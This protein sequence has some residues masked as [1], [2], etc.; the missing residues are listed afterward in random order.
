VA[1]APLGQDRLPIGPVRD[2]VV[3][4]HELYDL[5]GQPAARTISR[6]VFRS[7]PLESVSHETV[8]AL[9]RGTAVPAWGKVHSI[10]V[11]LNQMGVQSRDPMELVPHFNELWLAA[12]RVQDKGPVPAATI[13]RARAASLAYR[14]PPP[15]RIVGA[16]PA[17]T[18]FFTGR[19]LLLDT[20][21]RKLKAHPHAPL[22]LFGPGGVGKTQLARE[23]ALRRG[24]DYTLL[25]WV[26]ADRAE[27]ARSSLVSLA[28]RM[29]LPL[30]QSAERT[31][32]AV[33][34]RLESER[35]S[36]LLVFDSAE[37]DEVRQLIPTIGGHVIVTSRDPAWAHDSSHTGMEVPDFDEAEAIQFLRLRDEHMNGEQATTV[38]QT[39]GR[40]PL[41]LEQVA[42]LREA[43]GS[44]WE[45]L[46]ARLDEPELLASTAEPTHYPHTVARF[47]RLALDRL[48]ATNPTA[49][50]IF[51]LFAWFGSE[52]V[53]IPLL[54]QGGGGNL[55]AHLSRTL[56]D[57]IA[58]RHGV[59]AIGRYGLARL[60]NEDERI[61]VQPLI[62]LALRHALDTKASQRSRDNVHEIL[63]AANPGWPDDLAIL[64]MHRA[65]APHILSAGLV[66]SRQPGAHSAVYDQIRYRYITGDYEDALQLGEAAV[67]T[68]RQLGMLGPDHELVLLTTREWANALR[69][70]G[71]YS[72]SRELTEDA[73]LRLRSNP[74]YGDDHP[75]T[76]TVATSYAAD[77]RIAGEYRAALDIDQDTYDRLVR[78]YGEA[79]ERTVRCRHNLAVSLRL[80]GDFA[81]AEEVDRAELT[82][83]RAGGGRRALLSV[84]ALAED[85]Y[86]CGHYREALAEQLP[87]FEI[88]QRTLPP[89]DQ[90]VLLSRRNVALAQRR[91]GEVDEAVE[92]LR[93]NYDD[94]V[95]SLGAD[96]E[97]TLAGAMSLANALRQRGQA[98]QAYTLAMDAVGT[99]QQAFGRR[100]PLTLA[101]E[102]NFAAILRAQGERARAWR[103]DAVTVDALRE[104]VGERHPF[105]VAAMTNLATDLALI[106]DTSGALAMSERAYALAVEIRGPDHPD[107]STAAANLSLDRAAA[108][109]P[110]TTRMRD[111]VI[112]AFHR[113]VGSDHPIVRDVAAR[114]R[115]ECDIEPPST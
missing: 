87:S 89:S 106:G 55:T 76:L 6:E 95:M 90:V 68:W 100:N 15:S 115:L 13:S 96:H 10:V 32:A 20:M 31:I 49:A 86:G 26:P 64:E 25:W 78:R 92:L 47:L 52:P 19:E 88:S 108:G 40:L 51:E 48:T 75:H 74:R 50:L 4:L 97:Y 105:T 98:G 34:G 93:T 101:A 66:H 58:L 38:A 42:S 111:E 8:S 11:V 109:L 17:P 18:P 29:D 21:S 53:T 73:L 7:R 69:A 104:T 12:R 61:D 16:L 56:K 41:A 59:A 2:L 70:L 65:M 71:R 110:D 22:V 37:G 79:D 57:P 9:L 82:R 30:R 27:R 80:L 24:E 1:I 14:Q 99:Y 60:H 3:A 85:L 91:L 84:H 5:A 46:M 35:I 112:T 62:R 72:R 103:A 43:T 63:I 33:L 113:T 81:R 114:V 39:V 94:C 28:E 36:Y 54:R 107:T 67:T 102:V 83:H 77:L 45:E 23:Y 44:R